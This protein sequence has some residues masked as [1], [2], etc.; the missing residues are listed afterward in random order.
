MYNIHNMLYIILLLLHIMQ[1]NVASVHA[2]LQ[3]HFVFAPN[4]W[5]YEDVI[6]ESEKRCQ[7]QSFEIMIFTLD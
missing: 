2:A 5:I 3:L 1:Y 4:G 7:W 6:E